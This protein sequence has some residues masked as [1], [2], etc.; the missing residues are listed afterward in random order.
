MLATPPGRTNGLTFLAGWIAGI[1]V[2][3]RIVH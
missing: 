3:G 2:L 1:A